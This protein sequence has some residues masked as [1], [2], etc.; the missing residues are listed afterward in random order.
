MVLRNGGGAADFMAIGTLV[1]IDEYLTTIYRPD[2]DY[3][4]GMIEER[5]LGENDH[6]NLQTILAIYLGERRKEW[7][8]YVV[9][10]QRVQV[11]LPGFESRR[12]YY[13]GWAAEVVARS[14][15][16]R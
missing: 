5:N 16:D 13:P 1:S 4:D 12:L 10:E 8:I 14:R 7:G 6:A 3:V 9:V 2:C 15:T 11:S